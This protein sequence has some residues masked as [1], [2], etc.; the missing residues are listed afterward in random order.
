MTTHPP[1]CL[2]QN[3]MNQA[4]KSLAI[5]PK[6]ISRCHVNAV[7]DKVVEKIILDESDNQALNQKLSAGSHLFSMRKANFF[8]LTSKNTNFTHTE[9]SKV[10][11]FKDVFP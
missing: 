2:M 8:L 5:K 1:N 10:A 3:V 7:N 6:K 4:H 9:V 11:N